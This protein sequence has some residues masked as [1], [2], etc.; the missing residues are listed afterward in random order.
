MVG[1][2]EEGVRKLQGWWWQ[3]PEGCCSLLLLLLWW[4]TLVFAGPGVGPSHTTS[5]TPTIPPVFN[6]S[7]HH[8]TDNQTKA[9]EL[10]LKFSPT[11]R[12]LPD[13][14]EFFSDFEIRCG[15]AYKRTTGSNQLPAAIRER[16]DI[17]RRGLS[18]LQLTQ[19]SPNIT[20]A[21]SQAIRQL[22]ANKYLV[23]READKGSCIV[24][25]DKE[26]YIREGNEHL[27]DHNT[28]KLTDNDR[29]VELAH[30]ANWAVRHHRETEKLTEQLKIRLTTDPELSSSTFSVRS[31]RNP[32]PSD[33]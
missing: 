9:L 26:Q 12:E 4:G 15:W 19:A 25:M 33:L 20:P 23:I 8:L 16:M 14:L 18:T 6:I 29:T 7:S 31:T 27:G 11:P 3:A 24:V 32:M 17:M 13:P 1:V 10:G 28:Y 22:K 2:V 5:T 21:I 30:K